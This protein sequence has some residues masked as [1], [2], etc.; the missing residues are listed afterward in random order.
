MYE[1]WLANGT[2]AA[3][4]LLSIVLGIWIFG[5]TMWVL[6]L[7]PACGSIAG[8]ASAHFPW[9][10]SFTCIEMERFWRQAG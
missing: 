7:W 4:T 9:S 1:Q 6:L 3:A 8:P 10:A 5:V 2:V